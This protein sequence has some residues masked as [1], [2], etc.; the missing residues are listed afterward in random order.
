MAKFCP[1]WV[2]GISS[3]DQFIVAANQ[4][5]VELSRGR[6]T[7]PGFNASRIRQRLEEVESCHV[8]VAGFISQFAN[9][10][11]RVWAGFF[12]MEEVAMI[13]PYMFYP[14]KAPE[15]IQVPIAAAEFPIRNY[16]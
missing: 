15:S 13:S 5:T 7:L 6:D 8:R 9:Q 4:F 11:G 12:I 10:L 2:N 14:A 3:R 16:L 1:V